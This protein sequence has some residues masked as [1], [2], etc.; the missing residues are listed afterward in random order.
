MAAGSQF[1]FGWG[2]GYGGVRVG[3]VAAACAGIVVTVGEAVVWMSSKM[4]FRKLMG[5]MEESDWVWLP[6][7]LLDM[8]LDKLVSLS[9][10][11]RFGA[12]CK[13]WQSVAMEN[14]LK[15][16]QN[17]LSRQVPFLMVP[18]ED[19]SNVRRSLYSITDNKSYDFQLRVPYKKRLS[20]SSYGWLFTVE[21]SLGVTLMNPFSGAIIELPPIMNLLEVEPHPNH[22]DVRPLEVEFEVIKA[23]LSADPASS[24]NDYI[25]AAIYGDCCNLAFIRARDKAWTYIDKKRFKPLYDVIYYKGQ[26]FAVDNKYSVIMIDLNKRVGESKAPQVEVIELRTNVYGDPTYL[27]ESSSGDLLFV[28]RSYEFR[29]DSQYATLGFE[30]F[31]LLL[32]QFEQGSPMQL[33]G[34]NLKNLGGDTLFLGDNHSICVSASKWSGCQPNSIYYT[35]D[36]IDILNYPSLGRRDIGIFNIENGSF[37]THYNLD[38]SHNHMPPSIW[39]LPTVLGK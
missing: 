33:K 11:V 10:F 36:N 20:G 34:K 4:P 38:P 12:V 18:T 8:I 14:K 35:D 6:K 22:I 28:Q 27:V 19:N 13:P 32:E 17:K 3:A 26:I 2:G 37:G 29:D 30:V 23:I 16:V 1:G 9:E 7:N 5:S 24:P 21:E 39:I 31:K 15:F 25:V